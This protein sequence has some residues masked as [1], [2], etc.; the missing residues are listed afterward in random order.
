MSGVSMP[1]TRP[2]G[3][4][5]IVGSAACRPGPLGTLQR[6]GYSC[7]EVDD[8]YA[9]MSE[10]C[11]KP[12]AY[13]AMIVSL[14]SLYREELA[15]IGA[16]KRRWPHVDVWLTHTDGRHAALADA[17]RLGADGLLSDD[18]LHRT[19]IGSTDPTTATGA[20][21]TP[22]PSDVTTSGGN[23]ASASSHVSRPAPAT[24]SRPPETAVHFQAEKSSSESS[25][26]DGEGTEPILT[27]EEL[28]ALLAEQPISLP[29]GEH[30]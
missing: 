26:F 10:L 23:G 19:A 6:L 7:A 5:L 27:A 29:D 28:R 30:D 22:S 13:R 21:R 1:V 24:P 12:L 4:V 2:T 14:A 18:G 16:V 20:F 8:A 17:M 25:E 9:G 15:V 11:R 3:R